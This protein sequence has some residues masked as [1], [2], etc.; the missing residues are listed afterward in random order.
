MRAGR[1][2]LGGPVLA[3][4]LLAGCSSVGSTVRSVSEA[5][6]PSCPGVSFLPDAS[7]LTRFREGSLGDLTDV[8][9]ESE[10]R[11]VDASCSREGDAV[12]ANLELEFV[13]AKGPAFAGENPEIVYFVGTT[14]KHRAVISKEKLTTTAVIPPDANARAWKEKLAHPIPLAEGKSGS[15]YSIF[16]GF[17]LSREELDYN[18]R[19][20]GR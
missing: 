14:D 16:I 6:A 17:Q 15:D 1:F 13:L 8:R 2:C 10:I 18:R 4:V 5:V 11:R 9:F 7:K 3:L 19:W 20:Y 12:V